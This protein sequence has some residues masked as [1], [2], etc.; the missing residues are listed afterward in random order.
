[1]IIIKRDE[2]KKAKNNN[3]NNNN[4]NNK[5]FLKMA[6]DQ[7]L[8]KTWIPTYTEV[9]RSVKFASSAYFISFSEPWGF[10]ITKI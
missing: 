3:N 8:W 1:M 7:K 6:V 4:N 2:D 9:L 5:R 10:S